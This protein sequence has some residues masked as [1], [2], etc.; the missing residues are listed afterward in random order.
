LLND[1]RYVLGVN[2]S[3]YRIR[4]YFMDEQALLLMWILPERLGCSGP[5]RG[6]VHCAHA[7][8]GRLRIMNPRAF[9]K[10]LIGDLPFS[11]DIYW[12]LRNQGQKFLAV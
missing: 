6:R 10:N 2:A 4:R 12:I 7:W 3:S 11:A 5:N 8:N 1:G 9:V